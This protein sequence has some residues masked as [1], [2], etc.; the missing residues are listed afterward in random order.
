[1]RELSSALGTLDDLSRELAGRIEP[2]ADETDEDAAQTV[3]ALRG[4]RFGD[5]RGDLERLLPELTRLRT[6]FTRDHLAVGV[7]GRA[8]QGKSRLLQSLSGL[9]DAEIPSGDLGHCTGARSVLRHRTGEVAATVHFYSEDRFLRNVLGPYFRDL[10]L[11]DPPPSL[12]SFAR[13][14]LPAPGKDPN[15]ADLNVRNSDVLKHLRDYQHELPTYRDRIG[16]APERIGRDGIRRFVAQR[17]ADGNESP[18]LF[19]AVERAEIDCDFPRG[20]IGAVALADM[21]GLGDT[22]TG[23]AEQLIAALAGETDAALFVRKPSASGDYWADY[24]LD[25]YDTA[26]RADGRLR[27]ADWSYLVLNHDRTRGDNLK[28]CEDLRNGLAN[29]RM[30]F[31]EALI[32]DCSDPAAAAEGVLDPILNDLRERLPEMDRTL[33]GGVGDELAGTLAAVR[34]RLDAAAAVFAGGA[35]DTGDHAAVLELFDDFWNKVTQRIADLL[36]KLR[37][38]RGHIPPELEEALRECIDAAGRDLPVPD[39]AAVERLAT[40]LGG[41]GSAYE[42]LLN[43]RRAAF[44][45]HF[46]RLGD[47]LR[48]WSEG[49]LERLAKVLKETPLKNLSDADGRAFLADVRDV[50]AECGG[51]AEPLAG[52]FD[53]VAGYS[54]DYRQFVQHRVRGH[55]DLLDPR[56]DKTP[57]LDGNGAD[58]AQVVYHL[59]NQTEELLANVEPDLGEILRQPSDAAFTLVEEFGDRVLWA[60]DAKKAWR[61]VLFDLRDRV[62]PDAFARVRRTARDRAAWSAAVD[63][64]RTA[65]DPSR[66]DLT[67]PPEPP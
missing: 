61:K 45:R 65:A 27:Q 39:E 37:G 29:Q 50:L 64:A 21:P 47:D 52:G 19:R 10:N 32:A 23:Y 33:A 56:G 62:F 14:E 15:G 16:T 11:G 57:G 46:L 44:A 2:P 30:S 17:D 4:L 40:A 9:T 1:M 35:S 3:A 41:V 34:E 54:L 60:D 43:V 31:A 42:K 12:E 28:N 66:F 55:L 53:L 8:R 25:L 20:D 7:V 5:L 48:Q 38:E 67:A 26:A 49:V 22:G 18:A 24:D 6:R 63:T 13:T 59:S 51:K 36:G 58:A